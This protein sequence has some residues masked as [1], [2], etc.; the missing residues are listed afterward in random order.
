MSHSDNSHAIATGKTCLITGGASGL[1][2]ALATKY[3]EAGANVVIC[4]IDEQRLQHTV[5]E[6]SSKGAG[7]LKAIKADITSADEV[8]K[9]FDEI[10]RSF[11]K[12]DVLVNNAGIMDR[13][14]P[15]GDLDEDLWDK[16]MAVNLKAP[17]L[18]SK[19]AVKHMLAQ[20]KPDG[21]IFNI[22]SVAGKAGW[23]AGIYGYILQ[24]TLGHS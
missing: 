22:V 2:K 14:D 11:N 23:A 5:S 24:P 1:G 8:Q 3:L 19:L 18:L 17:F 7:T 10:S 20:E 9:L 6:L 21:C 13:F 15:V 16:V 12:L 4:D